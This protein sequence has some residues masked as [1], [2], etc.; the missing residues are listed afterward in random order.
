MHYVLESKK[1]C[2][3]G[4][5]SRR[6]SLEETGFISLA[7]LFHQLSST[8]ADFLERHFEAAKLLRVQF[9]EHSLHL[10]GMLSEGW[11]N[12]I[13]AAW[14]EAD[15]P[16]A[17]VFGAL[18]PSTATLIEPGVRST[19]GPITWTGKGPLRNKTSNTRKSESPRP[20]SSMPAAA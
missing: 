3:P 11:D 14:G 20:V 2:G 12:E 8:L 10:S 18:Y 6:V 16:N 7:P 5:D 9:G 4:H 17:S 19:T 15:D 1:A 13:L